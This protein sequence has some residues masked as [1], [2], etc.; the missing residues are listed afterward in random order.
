MIG[1]SRH[2]RNR[3]HSSPRLLAW[4][5]TLQA[6]AWGVFFAWWCLL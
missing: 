2:W 1:T 4:A 6:A 3:A 5:L